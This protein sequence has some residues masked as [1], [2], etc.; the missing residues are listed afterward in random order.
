MQKYFATRLK[1]YRMIFFFLLLAGLVGAVPLL[2]SACQPAT[3]VVITNNTTGLEFRHLYLSGSDNNWGPD[4]L[5][6]SV[7]SAG[8]TYTQNNLSCGGA[9]VKVIVEDQSGCFLYQT[10]S[11]GE[12]SSWTITNE[13]AP[14]CGN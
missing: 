13:A 11:C 10:V 5:N 9:G 7:I 4:Q 3:S 12:S 6:G 8:S 1:K 14:D 2:S